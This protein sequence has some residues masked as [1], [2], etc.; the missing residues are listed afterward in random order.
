MKVARRRAQLVG[1]GQEEGEEA[2]G[3][4]EE[5][6]QGERDLDDLREGVGYFVSNFFF[7]PDAF[8]RLRQEG[9]FPLVD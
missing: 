7:H 9:A 1:A 8:H 2:G 6:V 5:A 3:G 4:E